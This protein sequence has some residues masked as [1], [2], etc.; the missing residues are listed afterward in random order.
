[1]LQD[2]H[3]FR[4]VVA[5]EGYGGNNL[6]EVVPIKGAGY[7]RFPAIQGDTVVFVCEDD[8]WFTTVAGGPAWRLTAGVSE[9]SHPRL[10]PGGDRVA[11]VGADDGP[12]E[13]YVMSL[14]TGC[15]RRL[16]YQAARCAVVGWHPATGEIL[17]ASAAEQPPG[18]GYRLFAVDPAG[19]PPRVLPFGQASSVSFGPGGGTVLGR[20]TA[21][22]ARWKRYRGGTAGELWIDPDGTGGYRRLIELPG[23]VGGPCW[24]GDRVFFVS[25]HG[26]V[27]NVYSCRPDGTGLTR[28][29]G[30]DE[31][32]VRN[33][34]SDGRRLVYH[35]GAQLY[36]LDPVDSPRP[37]DV[38]LPSARFQRNRRYVAA[39]DFL[40][41][42]TLTPDGAGLA[43]VA[44][45]KAFSLGNWDGPV[46]RHGA[47]D[48]VRYQL[49]TWLN[50]G[51]RLVAAAADERPDEWFAI[52]SADGAT[53]P[54]ELSTMDL[55]RVVEVAVSPVHDRVA[56]ANHRNELYVVDLDGE[57]AARRV[58]QSPHGRVE[59]LAW[60]P[61]GRWLAYARPRTPQTTAIM[62]ADAAD[63]STYA[64]TRPVLK[65][66]APAF[67][68]GGRYLYFIGQRDFTPAYDQLGFGLGFPHGTRPYLVTLRADTPSPFVPTSRPFGTGNDAH[69]PGPVTVDLAGID[70]RV[71]P[72]PVAEGRYQK[73]L[74]VPGKALLLSTPVGE[75]AGVVEL[76]DFATLTADEYVT[77]VDDIDLSRDATTLLCHTGRRLRVV[78]SDVDPDGDEHPGA[79]GDD[80]APGRRSGWIDLDRIKVSVRPEAE[81]RQMFREAW[82]MQRD[83]FWDRG[84]SGVDWDA[85]YRRYLPLVDLVASRA[86]LSD[87]IWELQGELGTSHAY[88][89]GGEY[90]P[91]PQYAQGFLGVDWQFFDGA[92]RIGQILDGDRWNPAAAS[93]C[94]RLGVDLRPGD[95]VLAL[96]G[97]P[98][99]PAGPGELLVNQ[100]GQE[101]ELAVRR[102]GADPKTRRVV[103]RA[104]GDE[105]PLRYRDW[106][107]ANRR[108]VRRATGGRAGYLHVPNMLDTGYAEFMRAYL[109]EYDRDGLI[110]D[111]R[112]NGGGHV[113]W[114][115]LEKLAR[116]RI[117][118][119]L[120]RWNGPAPYPAES[121]RGPMVAITNEHAGSDGDIFSHLFKRLGLGPLVGRRT[122]GGVIATW[123]RHS[124]VDGTVTTQ[125]EFCYT[126]DDVGRGLENRGTEPD[127]EVDVPPGHTGVDPQLARAVEELMARLDTVSPALGPALPVAA[128]RPPTLGGASRV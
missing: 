43:V 45:G 113:S 41:S 96:G 67:D 70:R 36:L 87:L 126:F 21:D 106:V 30:H 72:F 108:Y 123:P 90:R 103:V 82:R 53:P 89:F 58:D 62:I 13:V 119:D 95:V 73:V 91:R 124:L 15:V 60:S 26:G 127:I 2:R 4:E 125:P 29:T 12:T 27:G 85:V 39:A 17:Y 110:I 105:G 102:R 83:H 56:V 66:F 75:S 6:P 97:Q 55:G 25:D 107:T 120:G 54:V 28:H 77:G 61:D 9:V 64:V 100:A 47:A 14:A 37:I 94:H 79:T 101:V 116:R 78:R 59:D 32:Y 40:H 115:L 128:Q 122:W 10:S 104:I 65:D 88:E 48:G 16:T 81:W 49:L 121:P 1:M 117:G 92:W 23:N 80:D 18:F 57:P 31:F 51:R 84:M 22:P 69:E 35:A 24:V 33:L 109:A 71:V 86:E 42:A 8:L 98:I 20:N 5:S 44:R 34:A 112:F 118:Y 114:L 111:V 3:N 19:G 52:L 76:F 11:F 46:R 50:D 68:P 99:G 7:L 74:G 93:P 38:R 63:W